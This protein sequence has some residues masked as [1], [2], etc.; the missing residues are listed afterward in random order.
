MIYLGI[1]GKA[2]S[3]RSLEI[4]NNNLSMYKWTR[5]ILGGIVIIIGASVVMEV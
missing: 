4:K 5:I 1:M 3:T 2:N